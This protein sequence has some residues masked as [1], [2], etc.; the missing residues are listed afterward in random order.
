MI[1][2]KIRHIQR[3]RDIVYTFTKY[4]FGFVMKELGLLDLLAVPKKVFVEGNK[5]LNTRTTG[6]RIRMFL[7]EI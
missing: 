4:G 3:Y 5:T 2:K 1:K 6:E 7:E